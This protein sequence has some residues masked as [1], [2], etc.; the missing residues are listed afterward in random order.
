MLEQFVL[1]IGVSSP[2]PALRNASLSYVGGSVHGS[3]E[4]ARYIA[5][6]TPRIGVEV[7]QF[8]AGLIHHL[9]V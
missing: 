7:I 6:Q 8:P 5:L 4:L 3:D 2:F 1:G 9:T